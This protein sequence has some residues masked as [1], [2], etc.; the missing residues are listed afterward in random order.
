MMVIRIM[1]GLHPRSIIMGKISIAID[2]VNKKL[3]KSE[4][5]ITLILLGLT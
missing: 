4:A 5:C 3:P 1:E 2:G